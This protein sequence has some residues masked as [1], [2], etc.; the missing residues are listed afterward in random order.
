VLDSFARL[1]E[2][3]ATTTRHGRLADLRVH[4]DANLVTL[5]CDFT[6]GDAAGQNMVTLAAD[7]MG[8]WL[9]EASPVKPRSWT[10]ESNMSGDKKA[11]SLAMH[12][13]RGKRVIAEA[14]IPSAVVAEQLNTTPETMQTYWRD[15]FVASSQAG[16]LGGQGQFAN[17][18]AALFLACG[19]DVACVAE[20]A[21][22]MS[23]FEVTET[24]ALYVSVNLP[25]LIVGTVGGGTGTP[26]ARECLALLGCQGE[27][28]AARFA[29]ICAAVV[30]AGE[31]SIVAA[32]AS[33]EFA[34]AHGSLGRRA[35]TG[36]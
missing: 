31:I 29:E 13:V 9:M 18:L 15:A 35:W 8:R 36:S 25:N 21:V 16:C 24:G 20:A 17:G 27:G 7:A 19:Q 33:G 32:L 23:R 12:F 10:V 11:S 14:E 6:T 1:Q 2:V 28:S 30:L 5:M 22:G 26:T 3:A 34:R 4:W